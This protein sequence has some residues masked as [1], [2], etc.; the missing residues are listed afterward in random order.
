[1]YNSLSR[2]FTLLRESI[3]AEELRSRFA[4][5]RARNA[6]F[7]VSPE[8]EDMILETLGRI[9]SPK[10]KTNQG[11]NDH[12]MSTSMSMSDDGR[13]SQFS[14]FT[15]SITSTPQK[16]PSS[17]TLG[18]EFSNNAEQGSALSN[19]TLLT[20]HASIGQALQQQFLRFEQVQGLFLYTGDAASTP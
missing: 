11:S 6:E 13:F 20:Q 16:V 19:G 2:R 1:M 4:E 18:S 7:Q 10:R 15:P 3:D 17:S 12:D 8:E 14:G 5:Q 9:R